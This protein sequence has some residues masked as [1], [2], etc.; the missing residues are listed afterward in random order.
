MAQKSTFITL[1]WKL[2]FTLFFYNSYGQ[3]SSKINGVNLVSPPTPTKQQQLASVK[4][5]NS[6]WVSIIPYGFIQKK[7]SLLI[8]DSNFQWWGERP[9]GTKVLIEQAKKEGLK[10]MLKPHIWVQ[11]DGW[12]GDLTFTSEKAWENWEASYTNYILTYAKIAEDYDVEIL[13]IGTELRKIVKLKPL[14]WLQLITKIRTLYKG[15]LTYAANWDNYLQVLF[16][17]K[18]DYIGIDAYFPLSEKKE[19]TLN[20]LGKSW[21]HI[22]K[23]LKSISNHYHK[24]ILFTEYGYTSTNFCT[25][26]PWK[27]NKQLTVNETTQKTAYKALYENIW[28]KKWFAGGFLWKWHLTE[29]TSRNRTKSFTPQGKKV[30]ETIKKAYSK[31]DF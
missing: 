20:D 13:C 14:F 4:K 26:E 5:V 2:L 28:G 12:G 17:H 16:W 8:Y 6:N 11:G 25:K 15:K 31:I 24:P 19:P 27:E 29:D 3:F 30:I 23:D 1:F 21:Q 18:L 9:K 22:N 10:I 7:S